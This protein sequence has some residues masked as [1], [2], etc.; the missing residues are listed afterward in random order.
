MAAVGGDRRQPASSLRVTGRHQC[1]SLPEEF[2]RRSA[3]GI[4]LAHNR[5]ATCKVVQVQQPLETRGAQAFKVALEL[6]G[7]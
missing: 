5:A 4:H 7:R 1:L 6:M 3:G 2:K